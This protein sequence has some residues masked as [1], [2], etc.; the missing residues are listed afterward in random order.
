MNKKHICRKC[1]KRKDDLNEDGIC[2]DCVVDSQQI[3][4]NSNVTTNKKCIKCGQKATCFI[5]TDK[6][7]TNLCL[8]HYKTFQS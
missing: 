8:E 3:N 5:Y 6:G 1:N 2:L 7:I 4:V